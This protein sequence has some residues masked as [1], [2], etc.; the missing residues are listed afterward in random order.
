M[1]EP[2]ARRGGMA[3]VSSTERVVL[4]CGDV[5]PQIRAEGPDLSMAGESSAFECGPPRRAAA[6]QDLLWD[7]TARIWG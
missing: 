3:N 7:Y 4:E 1:P 5:S 2:N 6:L